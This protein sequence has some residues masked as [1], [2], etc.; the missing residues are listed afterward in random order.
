M[1]GVVN[2]SLNQFIHPPQHKNAIIHQIRHNSQTRMKWKPS[3]TIQMLKNLAITVSTYTMAAKL[4]TAP[5]PPHLLCCIP[6]P[7]LRGVRQRA[8]SSI[9]LLLHIVSATGGQHQDSWRSNVDS[10]CRSSQLSYHN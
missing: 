4:T 1:Q 10:L 6:H 5:P 7:Y 8:I 3:E 9:F 2:N